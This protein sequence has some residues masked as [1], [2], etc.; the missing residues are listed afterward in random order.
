MSRFPRLR[1]ETDIFADVDA[2]YLTHAH[3]DHLDPYTLTRLWNELSDPPILIIPVSLSHLIPI[4]TQYLRNLEI[5]VLKP[6]CPIVFKGVELL[7]FFD[8]GDQPNN[9]EDVMILVLTHEQERVLIEAD[10]RLGLELIHFRQFVSMLMRA[11][12]LE[13]VVYLTTENELT[14]TMEGRNCSS[15]EERQAL[16]EYAFEE[17]YASVEQLYVP[18]D[19]P[20]DL[21]KEKRLLRLIYG[22]GLTA[23]HEL[24]ARWQK[25]LFPVRIDDRVQAERE[26]AQR[27]GYN[28]SIDS[29]HVGYT[30][31][32]VA[33]KIIDT[34]EIQGLT[35]LDNEEQRVFDMSIPFFPELPCAPLRMN[36]RDIEKQR[37]QISA[38]L[39]TYF[40]P[41]LLGLRQPPVLHLLSEHQ[42]MYR[43]QIHYGSVLHTHCY[44]YTLSF[45]NMSFVEK[46]STMEPSHEAYWANDL[47]DFWEGY[48]DEFS[49]FSRR[50]IPAPYMRLWSAM[51][52]PLL[53]SDMMKKRVELHFERAS[54]GLSAR[55]W[56]LEMYESV[57]T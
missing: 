33:G 52:T 53:N 8:V 23:P 40:L 6:H 24:D 41:F 45:E 27:Y 39:N 5:I 11:P 30:H 57:S 43:I 1:F 29:L 4:C 16:F 20:M 36:R 50:Q 32:V 56:V 13:T 10:A 18:F 17:L 19:D 54:Q 47:L 46:E 22:Q 12:H 2:V 51:A 15:I 14:G 38:L 21:W 25:I 35:M 42:G 31:T 44:D 7:G 34:H 48:C 28:H 49:T 37:G 9:E 55:S 3:C 26:V